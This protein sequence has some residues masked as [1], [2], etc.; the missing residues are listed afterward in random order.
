MIG[1]RRVSR[2]INLAMD[3]V[4]AYG[5]ARPG[6][7]GD[8]VF[9]GSKRTD[10]FNLSQGGSDS[11]STL[12]GDDSVYFGTAFDAGDR[13]DGGEG[14]DRVE[15]AGTYA[16]LTVTGDMLNHVETFYVRGAGTSHITIAADVVSDTGTLYIF[17]DSA[18]ASAT[19]TIDGAALTQDGYFIATAGNDTMIGSD[20]DDRFRYLRGGDD[21]FVGG[22]GFDRVDFYD[23][24][25]FSMEGVVVDLRLATVQSLGAGSITL[26]GFEAAWGTSGNDVLTGTASANWLLMGGGNDR[27]AA[28]AGDDIVSLAVSY[29]GYFATDASIDGGIGRDLLDFATNS[30][31]YGITVTLAETGLQNTGAGRFRIS[32]VEAVMGGWGEDEITGS[33]RKDTLAGG[34]A[35]DTLFG[36]AGDDILS[37]DGS[38]LLPTGSSGGAY[39]IDLTAGT[40]GYGDTLDG[41]SGEDTLYGCGGD[42]WLIG[43]L[44]ADRLIGGAQNDRFVYRGVAE[45]RG[46]DV[47]TIVDFTAGDRIDV[48]A[49][50][51]DAVRPNDQAFHF[52]TT[53]AHVGDITARYD[54]ASDVTIVRFFVDGDAKADMTIR[55]TGEHLLTAA[56]FVL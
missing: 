55:L 17:S 11:V 35:D 48:S 41:G 31:F 18:S 27:I 6:T 45:S 47:D 21:H 33:A 54:A 1:N 2:G 3:E 10:S 39:S 53:S 14:S 12:G 29:E 44:G 16:G 9:V 38:I 7:A 43:G 13:V 5:S 25:I 28:G 37:G 23:D 8:D 19:T 22:G 36:G 52:G 49:I 15:I 40:N 46:G 30:N 32:G 50:D 26:E 34:Y 4:V 20:H 51:A 24:A 42:D 56:D